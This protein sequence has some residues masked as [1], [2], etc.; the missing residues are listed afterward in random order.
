MRI[1]TTAVLTVALLGVAGFCFAAKGE[2]AAGEAK[3]KGKKEKAE[4]IPMGV[5]HTATITK[6]D[7]GNITVTIQLVADANTRVSIDGQMK[8]IADLKVGQT[9]EAELTGANVASLKVVAETET[10]KPK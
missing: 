3:S 10:A 5:K 4:R 1:L 8:T 9:V 2:K 6:I 7:G